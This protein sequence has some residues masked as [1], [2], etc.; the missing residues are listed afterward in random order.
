MHLGKGLNKN[1]AFVG[2]ISI[3]GVVAKDLKLAK[4]NLKLLQNTP[5]S[6]VI[7]LA[8]STASGIYEVIKYNS[9][10]CKIIC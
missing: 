7:S 4:Y 2:D 5:L 10:W 6:L 9:I 3:K 1:I 8:N